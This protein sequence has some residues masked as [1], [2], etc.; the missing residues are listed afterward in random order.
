MTM[1]T[2][3]YG[4]VTASNQAEIICSCLIMLCSSFVFAYSMNQIGTIVKNIS[5][6]KIDQK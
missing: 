6:R 4:D 5:E 1:T 2:V 3:G